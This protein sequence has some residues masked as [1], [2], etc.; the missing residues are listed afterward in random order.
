MKDLRKNVDIDQLK[1]NYFETQKKLKEQEALLLCTPEYAAKFLGVT[2]KELGKFNLK[3]V[4]Q[5]NDFTGSSYIA[6]YK[7][8][9]EEADLKQ[10]MDIA[11]IDNIFEYIL[12]QISTQ[13]LYE[14]GFIKKAEPLVLGSY[15]NFKD[16]DGNN[17]SYD[18]TKDYKYWKKEIK[19]A[20]I[21]IAK[22]L[23]IEIDLEKYLPLKEDNNL[24]IV[25]NKMFD[26]IRA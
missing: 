20:V 8:E 16:G 1:K 6:Y 10:K 18:H 21:P 25:I 11:S 5:V 19:K 23:E 26:L 22:K 13:V 2:V 15:S 14:E 17:L 24:N 9:V 7:S 12:M 3:S 4:K